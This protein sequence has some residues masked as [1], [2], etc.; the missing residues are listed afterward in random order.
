MELTTDIW[1]DLLVGPG[2]ITEANFKT[3][4][5]EATAA[6]PLPEIL[7]DKGLI[8]DDQLGQIVAGH[9]GFPFVRLTQATIL[10]EV[11]HI[12]PEVV[13]TRQQVI[14]FS[15]DKTGLKVALVDPTNKEELEFIAKKSGDQVTAYYATPRDVAG[16]LRRYEKDIQK[17][18]SELLTE[19]VTAAGQGPAGEVPL[20]KIVDLISEYAYA[21]KASDIHIEP[22]AKD[23]LV[24]FRIDGVLHDI[25]NIPKNLHDQVVTRIKVLA[26]LR[27]D[28]HLS[29]QDGKLQIKI[30]QDKV[31]IRVSIVPIVAGEKIVMRLLS[32]HTRQLFLTD[33][34]MNAADLAKVKAGFNK[35]YGMVLAT[36]P[37]GSGKT[38]S[39]YA[40]L[41][42]LNTREKNIASI[43]DPVEYDIE[44]INQIQVNAKTNLTFAHGLRSILR[45]DP[46]IIFVGEIRDKET[47][48]IA[49]NSAMTGHLVLSTLHTNNAAT[50][51]PRLIDMEI[52]PF[53]IASTVNTIIAQ[54]LVR[55][56]CEQCRT[57][58]KVTES[59][60]AKTVSLPLIKK[61]LGSK[62]E[63]RLYQGKGCAV[64]HQTGYV[65]VVEAGVAGDLARGHHHR[66]W[67]DLS[68]LVHLEPR[69]HGRVFH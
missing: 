30:E 16:A 13:A 4:V 69:L 39:I 51:L 14:A 45:Q 57:S 35:P 66:T 44:G 28:E 26:K 33:L 63:L 42:I 24:R 11:L 54:R 41:T 59:V 38:S 50:T 27:T 60:L 61:Y 1:H 47:A 15:K 5:L 18:F 49:V 7:L 52:E 2:H 53:L 8:A 62:K 3:A 48:G 23:S 55:K 10:P 31:D 17:S 64:C 9:L 58:V 65:A 12:V 68:E 25:L 37:T 19:E 43:E 21:N 56:I 6:R 20:A 29:A 22:R 46:D 40:I 67:R 32:S 34:G 36:G